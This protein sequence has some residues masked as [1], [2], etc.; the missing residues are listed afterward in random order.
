[1]RTRRKSSVHRVGVAGRC[2]V[3]NAQA[4][5]QQ[6]RLPRNVAAPEFFGLEV[7]VGEK[8][9]DME[10]GSK[11]DKGLGYVTGRENLMA[12]VPNHQFGR[13]TNENIVFDD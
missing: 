11:M 5:A 3:E 8:G 10:L 9:V 12:P 2:G 1:M 7:Y 13:F 6:D 4:R